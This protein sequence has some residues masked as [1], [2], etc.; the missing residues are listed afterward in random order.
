MRYS[1]IHT[2]VVFETCT[3]QLALQQSLLL[4]QGVKKGKHCDCL[5]VTAAYAA[6]GSAMKN[7]RIERRMV[8]GLL[9]QW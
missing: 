3:M 6:A 4:L 8:V 2:S 1:I 9:E 5:G 7:V